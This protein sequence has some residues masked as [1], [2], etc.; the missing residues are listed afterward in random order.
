MEQHVDVGE[1]ANRQGEEVNRQGEEA[2]RQG[3]EANRQGEE[4]NR[5]VNKKSKNSHQ[6]DEQRAALTKRDETIAILTDLNRAYAA[7]YLLLYRRPWHLY[8]IAEGDCLYSFAV[9]F[10]NRD[11][12]TYELGDTIKIGGSSYIFLGANVFSEKENK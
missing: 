3:E 8:K 4:A 11:P 5:C 1:E 9:N 6:T 12:A 7:K 10:S 2:N